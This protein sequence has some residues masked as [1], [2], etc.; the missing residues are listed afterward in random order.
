MT[1]RERLAGP[2]LE[3]ALPERRPTPLR[4]LAGV[5][6][7]AVAVFASWSALQP[8]RSVHAQAAASDRADKGQLE[9]AASIANIA[10]QRNPLSVDP[11]FDLSAIEQ[12]RGN[13]KSAVSALERAV[14]LEPANP[15]TWRRLGR[16]RLTVLKDP[17]GALSAFRAALYLDPRS[18][19][20][21]SDV[22]VAS[23]L[24]NAS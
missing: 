24:V 5:A 10:H 11:L 6:I 23:R 17:K 4:P 9:A 16:M 18:L 8:V 13:T 7:I 22:V 3:D 12:A 21:V 1:L 20:A 2:Q 19:K 14:D 15:E